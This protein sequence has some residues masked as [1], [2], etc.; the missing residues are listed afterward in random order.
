M[1]G[2]S[3]RDHGSSRFV[4]VF[5]THVKMLSGKKMLRHDFELHM[6]MINSREHLPNKWMPAFFHRFPAKSGGFSTK[7]DTISPKSSVN[8]DV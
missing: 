8:G 7:S 3:C 2:Q 6:A 4:T 1:R 5:P